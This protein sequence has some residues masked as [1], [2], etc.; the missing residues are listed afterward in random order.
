MV[1]CRWLRLVSKGL[2]ERRVMS[3]ELERAY[4]DSRDRLTALAARYVGQD[5]EDMV[6]SVFLRALERISGF[7]REAAPTTWLHRITVNACVSDHRK[8]R[9]RSRAGLQIARAATV[10][11]VSMER[12]LVR[13]ALATLPGI[14]RRICILHDV[15]G[16]THQEIAAAL[17][18]PEGT[19]KW[20]LT[21]ARRRLRDYISNSAVSAS[22]S[23][24][25]ALSRR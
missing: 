2:H 3:H 23:A 12:T 20:R 10:R 18:V 21:L 13:R 8:R 22:N 9:L 19:S 16:Y 11:P 6:Q 7:R 14:D 25:S 15:M 4:E 17:R 1:D 24:V 5:A